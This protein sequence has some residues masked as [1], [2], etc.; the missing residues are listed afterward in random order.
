MYKK[1]KS[2]NRTIEILLLNCF[3]VVLDSCDILIAELSHKF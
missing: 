2:S 1:Y 3:L